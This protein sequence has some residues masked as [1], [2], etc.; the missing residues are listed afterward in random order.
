MPENLLLEL[1]A[2]APLAVD[3]EGLEKQGPALEQLWGVY[4]NQVGTAVE[5]LKDSAQIFENAWREVILSVA[6]GHT[7]EMQALR[8]QIMSTFER[9]LSALKGVHALAGK[10]RRSHGDQAVPD[11]DILLPEIAGMER[12]K[13]RVFDRWRT[14]EDLEDLAARDYPLTTAD[15]DQIGPQRRPPASYYAEESKPF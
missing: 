6:R 10:L 12:Q 15:L 2:A 14:A 4:L 1:E 5:R 11:P 8:P 3:L 7:G 9:C 13:T